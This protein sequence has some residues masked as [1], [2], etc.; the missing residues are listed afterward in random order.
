M[1]LTILIPLGVS[2]PTQG[3]VPSPFSLAPRAQHS[4]AQHVSIASHASTVSLYMSSSPVQ[5]TPHT[6][7]SPQSEF[8]PIL[9]ELRDVAMKLHTKEQAPREGQAAAPAK[10]AVPYVPTHADYLQF[11]V[12]SCEVYKALEKIVNRED[13]TDELGR[14]RNSG[15]E[16]TCALEKDIEWMCNKFNL[17]KPEAGGAGV[18]YS[19]EL[20]NMI[21]VKDDGTKEGI[22]EFIC[23]YY[24]FYFAH[25]AGGRMIGKQM[26]KMLLDGETLEFYKTELIVFTFHRCPDNFSSNE[27]VQWGDDVNELKSKV[28][29]QIEALARGWTREERDECI[30]A[31]SAAFKGGGAINGYL[32]GGNPH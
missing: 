26:S 28:K 12:D 25:L 15:L 16:R 14:F 5:T 27:T 17:P 2:L 13:L 8:P 22:P 18:R 1:K 31:T 6:D 3:F 11:L 20:G 21:S 30:N 24:N 19:D 9:I 29:D 10:P 32:Y 7:S 4:V 23:H